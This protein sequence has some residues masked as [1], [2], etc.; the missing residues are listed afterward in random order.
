MHV[1]DVMTAD[2]R[3]IHPDTSLKEAARAMVQAGVSGLPVV[4]DDG[5][6]VGVLSEADLLGEEAKRGGVREGLRLGDP[7][8]HPR[9]EG[10][11]R[12]GDLMTTPVVTASI[13][14]T[15]DEAARMML[16]EGVKRLPVLDRS[17]RL[18]GIVSRADV[19]AAYARPDEVI[20]DQIREDVLGREI[21]VDPQSIELEVR[22]G[23]VLA[24][25]RLPRL[26]DVLLFEELVRRLEGVVELDHELDWEVDDRKKAS[27]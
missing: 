27:T 9:I 16:R 17:G 15:V 26:T 13:E 6:L 25:G 20:E 11:Q 12:A 19:V 23:V 3:T 8:Y 22:E 21:R 10:R 7:S 5:R 1:I 24:G 14:T 2:V 18:V 4:A